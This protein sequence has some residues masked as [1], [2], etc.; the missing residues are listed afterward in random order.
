MMRKIE[1][2]AYE[3]REGSADFPTLVFLPGFRSDM[4]GLKAQY[5]MESAVRRN[6]SCLLLDYSGHGQS[7]GRFEDGTIGQWTEDALTV[8]RHATKGPL[9]LIGSS[10]GGWIALLIA[11]AIPERVAGLI[12]IAA[13][14]DFTRSIKARLSEPYKADLERQGFFAVPSDYGD[15]MII[16]QKFL[17]EGETQCL[18]DKPLAL[19]IPVT[20]I[21]GKL[22]PDVPWQTAEKIKNILPEALVEIIYVE[23]GDHRLSRDEDLK[24]IDGRVDLMA[25]APYAGGG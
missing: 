13:A 18:L 10:M 17:E 3:Y 9:I 4:K 25:V 11:R 12:G 5:L 19:K 7:E 15:D 1:K 24:I 22:D 14:P 6:Q 8:I 23:D 20:L 21:Q 2:L 16:T